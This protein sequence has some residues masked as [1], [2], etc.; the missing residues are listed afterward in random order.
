MPAPVLLPDVRL[1]LERP[2]GELRVQL[3]VEGGAS[4]VQL[5]RVFTAGPH[6]GRVAGIAAKPEELDRIIEALQVCR[7]LTLGVPD[8][9]VA[10]RAAR[11]LVGL[12]PAKTR[13]LRRGR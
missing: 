6:A 1:V 12:G 13:R 2:D 4:L 3:T 7:R 10:D 8:P 5:L 9:K 11:E